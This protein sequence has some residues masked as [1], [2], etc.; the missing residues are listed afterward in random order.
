M[1]TIVSCIGILQTSIFW[2]IQSLN[3]E[4][5]RVS[6][7]FFDQ[8]LKT[9][10]FWT[11]DARP[12]LIRYSRM[13]RLWVKPIRFLESALSNYSKTKFWSKLEKVK[14]NDW[15]TLKLNYGLKLNHGLYKLNL[16]TSISYGLNDMGLSSNCDIEE[17]YDG[18]K[19]IYKKANQ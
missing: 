1:T 18:P 19:L 6:L 7:S 12:N 10:D 15:D 4:L 13:R 5:F 11:D 3:Y 8:T 14:N 9:E 2:G 17:I 16:Y